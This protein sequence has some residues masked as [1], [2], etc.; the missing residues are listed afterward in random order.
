MWRQ[1]LCILMAFF[2][3][4]LPALLPVGR[5]AGRRKVKLV[6]RMENLQGPRSSLSCGAV[7]RK[8][9]E[10]PARRLKGSISC[11]QG[12]ADALRAL[13]CEGQA[14]V[15]KRLASRKAERRE[16]RR[17]GRFER[18]VVMARWAARFWR[19]ILLPQ[20]MCPGLSTGSTVFHS[21]C[22]V[23]SSCAGVLAALG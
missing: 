6:S 10:K 23:C 19:Q 17:T 15:R 7:V 14:F 3:E 16:R 5:S 2:A 11:L 22:T 4:A 21:K 1:D 9:Q 8:G 20:R 18:I 13:E 12:D